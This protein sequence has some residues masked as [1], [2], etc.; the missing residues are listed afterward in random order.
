LVRITLTGIFSLAAEE[1]TRYTDGARIGSA[2][3][4]IITANN[5]SSAELTQLQAIVYLP[6]VMHLPRKP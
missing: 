4:E 5:H 2:E 3:A 1:A 6:V